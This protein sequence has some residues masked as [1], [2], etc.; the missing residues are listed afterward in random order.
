VQIPAMI[1]GTM[2]PRVSR[3][4]GSDTPVMSSI[5]CFLAIDVVLTRIFPHNRRCTPEVRRGG[6]A[7]R[8]GL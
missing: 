1:L 5:F 8:G 2:L 6:T 3:D 7:E 4:G